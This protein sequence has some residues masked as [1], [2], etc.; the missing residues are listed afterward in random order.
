[1][2]DPKY[3]LRR[4]R[5]IAYQLAMIFTVVGESTATYT[6]DRYALPLR[7]PTTDITVG[8]RSE[9]YRQL[10]SR[11]RNRYLELQ[12]NVEAYQ[13]GASLYNNDVVG[14]GSFTIFAGVYTATV[15]VCHSPIAFGLHSRHQ[16]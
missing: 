7:P 4:Q 3:Y 8:A 13:P 2:F 15:F 5:F 11:Y 6:L 16:L 12:K 9:S 14:T 10:I 1:M